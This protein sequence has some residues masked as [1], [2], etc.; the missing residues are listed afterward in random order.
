MQGGGVVAI[1]EV[2][3]RRDASYA[4]PIESVTAAKRQRLQR[5]ALQWLQRQSGP[6]PPLRF[7]VVEVVLPPWRLP[8]VRHHEDAFRP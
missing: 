2:K 7:D 1:V 5:L 8:R 3:T 4:R 6:H